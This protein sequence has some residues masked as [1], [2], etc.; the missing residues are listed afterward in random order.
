MFTVATVGHL[1]FDVCV[2]AR[3][4]F[5][6]ADPVVFS[7][8]LYSVVS[9][10]IEAEGQM[11]TP[12]E[13]MRL[14]VQRLLQATLG[15][16][17]CHGPTLT[18]GLKVFKTHIKNISVWLCRACARVFYSSKLMFRFSFQLQ[19]SFCSVSIVSGTFSSIVIQMFL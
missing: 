18:Q 6:F 19:E 2:C 12:L 10:D 16:E 8:S 13:C 17:N 4:V 3:S 1:Y 7:E 5:V 15:E 14:V 11:E 9:K